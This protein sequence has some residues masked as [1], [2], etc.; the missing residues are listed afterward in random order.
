MSAARR[1]SLLNSLEG[2]RGDGSRQ[3]AAAG[4]HK[5]FLGRP[6]VVNNVISLASVPGHPG[7]G[8]GLL[9]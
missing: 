9:P 7:Q 2:K 8:R 6:T 5:G 4:D 3:A 1:S